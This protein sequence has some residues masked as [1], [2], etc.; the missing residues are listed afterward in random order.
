MAIE[1]TTTTKAVASGTHLTSI[2]TVK[3]VI[4]LVKAVDE[5]GVERVLQVGDKVYANETIFT[6]ADG[7]VIVEFQDGTHLDLPRSTHI[8]LDADIYSPKPSLEQQAA[9]EAA[10]I[11]KAIAEGR[12]PTLVTDAA[13]A[14]GTVGDEGTSTPLV[15]DFNNTQGN[16]T[17]GYP[18]GPISVAFPPP[19]EELPPVEVVPA[20]APVNSIPTAG[21]TPIAVDEDDI[22]P[23]ERSTPGWLEEFAIANGSNNNFFNAP[24]VGATD[25]NDLP[26]DEGPGDNLPDPS[27]TVVSGVLNAG[28]GADG[29][30]DIKFDTAQPLVFNGLPIES[31]GQP[32]QYWVSGD[33]HT[34]V[35]FITITEYDGEGG[36]S[37]NKII[38]SAE[39]TDSSTGAYSF[40]LYGQLDHPVVNTEDNI[41]LNLNFTITDSNGDTAGGVLSVNVD[42]DGPIAVGSDAGVLSEATDG[43]GNNVLSGAQDIARAAFGAESN[44]DLGND[45]L[46][47][48]SISGIISPNTDQDLF[49]VELQAGETIYID[50]D[51]GMPDIDT[52]L[53]FYD[54][55]GNVVAQNDDDWSS[56]SGSGSVYGY[57]SYIAYTVPT[58]GVYYIG[59]T[60]Y[61][62]FP[63]DGAIQDYSGY[64]SGDY[65]LNLSI[66]PTEGSTGLGSVGN[67]LFTDSDSGF[68]SG[69]L[70]GSL[71]LNYG[72]DGPAQLADPS[73]EG[74]WVAAKP[75]FEMLGV[76]VIDTETD[77]AIPLTSGGVSV[78]LSETWAGTELTVTGMAGEDPVYALV[79]DTLSGNYTFTLLGAIDHPDAG[80]NGAETGANDPLLFT[81]DFR[82]TDFDG[83]STT[84]QLTVTINDDGP[85]ADIT[86][87]L[88]Y[89]GENEGESQATVT[90]DETEDGD[91][92]ADAALGYALGQ[93]TVDLF[94]IGSNT[95][96]GADG[97]GTQ[98]FSL[99][100]GA[101]GEGDLVDSG[102]KTT[103]GES[104]YLF[105]NGGTIEGRVGGVEGAVAL[106]LSIN[107]NGEVT[108]TQYLSLQHPDG[109]TPDDS[110][111]VQLAEGSVSAVLT[112]TDGDGDKATDTLDLTGR[113]SFLDDGPSISL[114]DVTTPALSVDETT[115][116]TNDTQNFSGV[117]AALSGAD[118]PVPAD[119]SYG[120]SISGDGDGTDSGLVDSLTGQAVTLWMNGSDIEGQNEDGEVVFVISVDGSG[121]VTLDQQRAVMHDSGDNPDTSEPVS[122]DPNL[123]V[124]TATVTDADGDTDSAEI[125]LGAQI[126]FLDDGPTLTVT[127]DPTFSGALSVVEDSGVAGQ[128]TVT[129]TA[130]TFTASAVDGYSSSVSYGLALNG[131]PAT[132]LMTT[133]GNHAI[134][135]VADSATQV[136]GMYDSNGDTI[137]DATAFTVVLSGSSVTLTSYEAL[138]HDNSQGVSEDNTLDLGSL[139]N[140]VA[141]VTVTDDD[142]DQIVNSTDA[143]TALSLTISDTDPTL[144]VTG[145]PT[146][147]G[148][149]S[150]VEDSGVAG[151]Q[152]VTITAPTFTASAVDGYS[153][154]VSYGLALNGGPATGLMTT[155][156]NHA[157]T[158]VADSATQVSGMYDSNGDTILDAT[159]FTV[160]LSGSSVTLTSYEALEHDNSQGVSED[161]TLDL[162]SLI[163]VVATVT[164]T[165]DDN[166]QIVNSTDAVTALSLTFNDTDP[167]PSVGSFTVTGMSVTEASGTGNTVTFTAPVAGGSA[168]DGVVSTTTAYN[169]ALVGTDVT[170]LMTTDGNHAIT[171]VVDSGSQIS[172]MYDSDGNGSL[173]AT[174][175]TVS[176]TGTSVTLTSLVA[177]EH[178]NSPAGSGAGTT[179]T[180]NNLIKVEATVS[181]TD[182]D[183]DV[184]SST[185]SSA[186]L[187][188][189]FADTVPDAVDEL[190]QTLTESHVVDT[191][192]LSSSVN[193][194]SGAGVSYVL[195]TT[196]NGLA[197]GDTLKINWDGDN[198]PVNWKLVDISNP[199]NTLTGTN[200]SNSN[201]TAV[202]SALPANGNYLLYVDF[203][204]ANSTKDINIKDVHV[205]HT[206]TTIDSGNVITGNPGADIVGADGA[207][208]SAIT[209]T[210]A[211]GILVTNAAVA[212]GGSTFTTQYGTLLIN[213]DGS[214]TYTVKL[215]AAPDVQV[216]DNFIYTLK[217]GDGD[218]DTATM[219]YVINDIKA[220]SV[221]DVTMITNSNNVVQPVI[222]TFVDQNDPHHAFS[223]LFALNSQ[224]QQG[225]YTPDTGFDINGSHNYVVGLEAASTDK[226]ILT[227]LTIEGV[228]L[229]G[230]ATG[231]GGGT[232]QMQLDNGGGGSLPTGL[233]ALVQPNTPPATQALV[234]STDGSAGDDSGGTMTD[235]T[236]STVNYLYGADG[237]DTL[238][239]SSGSEILNGGA[240]ADSVLGG[241]GNDILVYDGADTMLD[242]GLGIDVLRIDNG[243]MALFL[244]STLNQAAVN[245]T[246]NTTIHGMEVL[247]ITDDAEGSASKGTTLTL[248]AQ[249]VL[250]FTDDAIAG[251]N[252]LIDHTLYVNGNTSDVVN[253]GTGWTDVG[254]VPG[255]DFHAYT[256]T[257][258]TILVT[259]KVETE[260]QVNM[261]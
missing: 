120:L 191:D 133:A 110:E 123:V 76:S 112:V 185:P 233:V 255:S 87:V 69:M 25:G 15:I 98:E 51:Y 171:L 240:G 182:G 95:A 48:V 71:G 94:D 163:N 57:D 31:G 238:N 220:P 39:I 122:I 52:V 113:I 108:V 33:G 102:L 224:G 223:R 190:P 85:T 226:V 93:A 187:N 249:D 173:D 50:I 158:L 27:P 20:S 73:T 160:V 205:E 66:Q 68:T 184:V 150:V 248:T 124:L 144:T 2:G 14:G 16:V 225:T 54:A 247:L 165:D 41:L 251:I 72:A 235:T 146:F 241:D 4:G 29:V 78:T 36:Y 137:L 42:D 258:N 130:P 180:L 149:L 97:P 128:Q 134:T 200:S 257:I 242:G 35:G 106:T 46:P 178:Q 19:Q 5:N 244:D 229:F 58:S 115:L 154:S 210:N 96:Y 213:P 118:G 132:G 211:S 252:N 60:S 259:L 157:I 230:Q 170:G 10:R 188:L 136:S 174:A 8:V 177:L 129:I 147:S 145:D 245:L 212:V 215:N 155:A 45:A 195:I 126:S 90:V 86:N 38:F 228:P 89:E 23:Q 12:D 67:G 186:S 82:V 196:I 193:V 135:L 22:N 216:T 17:S 119:V 189:S 194:V 43:L 105:D 232:F 84:T 234:A 209:Y 99:K 201:L 217:D 117:F 131:G 74:A 179:L 197:I 49:K 167:T 256:Q 143:V 261:S 208:V 111:P 153:S 192:W 70:T 246:G 77:E 44:S 34:V 231:S 227:D 101:A 13:A 239:G 218:T 162:G 79:I 28:F 91:D 92:N 168:V 55:L 62:D 6:S 183:G 236:S 26:T 64:D 175:F 222:L 253:I 148:A 18:T 164:V 152:T 237:N 260:V 161:N 32:V 114:A 30:G 9:D 37:Y 116:G 156:G 107:G 141:T 40:T 206:V 104:I 181:M 169:L 214:Y 204:G 81:F 21:E 151:Q 24:G 109:T 176:L 172:G 61:G 59:V 221:L 243:A 199:A 75:N 207:V 254:V 121:N 139:I 203:D 100:L 125:D 88:D 53:T 63:G 142:N 140:V 250:N 83:D 159:A 138:E 65:V 3:T 219:S 80:V 103:A 7:A 127:G 11:E 47:S 1:H 166:D 202:L 198:G 56:A